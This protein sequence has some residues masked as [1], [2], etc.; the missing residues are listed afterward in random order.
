MNERRT[1]VR[2]ERIELPAAHLERS[3]AAVIVNTIVSGVLGAA[4]WLVAA[5]LFDP[6]DVAAAIAAS[7][8]LIAGSFLAQLNLGTA[9]GRFLPGAGNDR[10]RLVFA[11]YRLAMTVAGV[12]AVATVV[13]GL[14]RGGSIVSGGDRT[15]TFVLAA[16]IP[17]WVVFALQDDA[18]VALRRA[19]WLPIENSLVALAKVA[20]LPL[21]LAMPGA[22]ALLL[23]WTL[24]IVPAI[25]IVN[26]LLFGPLVR[27]AAVAPRSTVNAMVRFATAD[28]VGMAATVLSLRI[29]PL[30][31]VEITGD[32]RA[33]YVGVPWS[34]LTVLVVALTALSRLVLSEMSHDP[35]ASRRVAAR[36]TRLVM[37]VFVPGAI[38]G[39]LLAAPIMALAGSGYAEH[40]TW[41]LALGSLGL[42]PAALAECRMAQLR[43]DGRMVGVTVRQTVRAVVLLIGVVGVLALDRPDLIGVV[44]AV[45]GL[46]SLL[47]IRRPR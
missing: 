17:L 6:I 3:T 9:F 28:L 36:T 46:L 47:Y 35:A 45:T 19:H 13:I 21:L 26:G 16:S 33:A 29:V 40:G 38:A 7:S 11:C 20:L 1:A 43:F 37:L 8:I 4:F 31:V 24:P 5:M 23:A 15:L 42:I 25:L 10:R 27:S 30:L 44:F 22:G 18:L 32:D 2:P 41:V 14:A 12:F 39:A 34:I